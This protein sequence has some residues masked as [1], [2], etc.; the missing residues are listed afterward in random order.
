MTIATIGHYLLTAIVFVV[1]LVVLVGA[2][3]LGHYWFARLFKMKVEEFAIGVGK[4][5]LWT[6][7]KP[8]QPLPGEE[9]HVVPFNLR[10]YPLGGFVRIAGMEPRE[11]GEEVAVEHGFFSKAPWQRIVVLFAGPV[12]SVLAGMIALLPIYATMGVTRQVN[13]VEGLLNTGAAYKAGVRPGDKILAVDGQP[14][15][16]AFDAI[17]MIRDSGGKPITFRIQRG[18]QTFDLQVQPEYQKEATPLLDERMLPT[19]ESKRQYKVGMLFKT[20]TVKV[21]FNEAL[22]ATYEEPKSAL[23]GMIGLIRNPQRAEQQAGGVVTMVAAT[24]AVVTQGLDRIVWF[25]ALLSISIGFFNLLPIPPLDGGQMLIAFLEMLRGGKRLPLKLQL[26]IFQTGFFLLI[27]LFVSV[28]FLDVKRL[29]EMSSASASPQDSR[30]II[31]AEP[32]R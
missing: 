24:S 20:A 19:G 26:A 21:S 3:E 14:V 4:P 32:K 1:I 11:N 27:T 13:T 28:L 18:P 15:K 7:A 25:A 29:R 2:H 16:I 12:F 31:T 30:Q 5:I 23:V 17:K 6:F 22:L 10:P 8:K 9:S